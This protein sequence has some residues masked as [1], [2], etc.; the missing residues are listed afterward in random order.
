M[1]FEQAIQKQIEMTM[2]LAIEHKWDFKMRTVDRHTIG[3]LMGAILAIDNEADAQEFYQTYVDWLEIQR[4][5]TIPAQ[6]VADAHIGWCFGEGMAEDR[7][8][9]W[10]KCTTA[11]HPIFGRSKPSPENALAAGIK[12]AQT[13]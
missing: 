4:D 11:S 13:V 12:H 8:A 2:K 6:S 7:K 1:K 5:R 10:C 9:M 3:D